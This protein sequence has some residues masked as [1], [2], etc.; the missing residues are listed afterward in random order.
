MNNEKG[1]TMIEL[2]AVIIIISVVALITAPIVLN[3][4]ESAEK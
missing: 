3:V 4:I 2:V 1:F